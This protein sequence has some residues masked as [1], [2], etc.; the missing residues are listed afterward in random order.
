V[1]SNSAN[2]ASFRTHG[3]DLQLSYTQPMKALNEALAGTLNLNLQS[4]R[5]FEYWTST[6]VSALFPNGINRAGQTGAGFGGP[7]GLPKWSTNAQLS[8][9]LQKLMVNAQVRNISRGHYNNAFIGPDQA[10]YS[11]TLSNSINN[12]IVP[13]MTYVN[14]G[15]SYDFGG[16]DRRELFVNIDNLFDRTPPMP[17]NNNAYYDLMGRTFR[18]GLR[19]S[20]E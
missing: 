19:V 14:L 11:A 7:A 3:V 12:N 15:V 17:A 4:T 2:V 5:V 13:S 1:A 20:F 10:G 18:A 6:D 16:K 9:R 8:Y